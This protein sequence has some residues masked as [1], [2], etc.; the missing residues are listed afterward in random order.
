[1]ATVAGIVI[2]AL[3]GL[4]VVQAALVFMHLAQ[5][6]DLADLTPPEPEVWPSVSVVSAAR[7]EASDIGASLSSRLADG[8]PN[9]EIVVIDDR[10]EDA[11]PGIIA[12]FASRDPRVRL[13]RVDALPDGWLG[14]VHALHKGVEVAIGEWLLFSDADVIVEPEMLGKAV[15]HC[16]SEGYDLLALVPEFRSRSRIVGVLWAIFMRVIAMVISPDAVRDTSSKVAM[17]SGGFT[18][19]RR[20]TFDTTAGFH[21]LRLETADDVALGTMVKNAGGRC[22]FMNGRNAATVSI[23]GSLGEFYRGVEKNGSSLAGAPFWLVVVVFAVLGCVEYSPLAAIALGILGGVGWLAALGVSAT[24]LAT[25]ATA[26]ALR[27]NTGQLWP[28]LLWP[29]G[30]ALM[31]SGVLRSAWLFHRRGGAMWRGTFYPKSEVLAAQ[32]FK[33]G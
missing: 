12:E 16:E 11:T 3:C 24:L 26:A 1:V 33:L 20:S 15:A 32:R 31:T 5:I 13:V 25:A 30:W 29:V 17:G 22:D 28:A 4:W 8:Y 9:L 19:V 6:R 21:H 14:K 2:A 7:N 27:R 23:Y 10:S 18:L